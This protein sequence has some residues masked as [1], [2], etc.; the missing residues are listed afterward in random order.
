MVNKNRTL[1][2]FKY[3]WNHTDEDHPATTADIIKYLSSIDALTTWKTV[4]EDAT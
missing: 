3:L 4:S 2:I 1:Y